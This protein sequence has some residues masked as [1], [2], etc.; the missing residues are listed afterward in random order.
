[1]E[2]GFYLFF[3]KII[4]IILCCFL[5]C[6]NSIAQIT[7]F[8]KRVQLGC[9][10]TILTSLEVTDSCY[11]ITGTARDSL[12]CQVNALFVKF[13]TLGNEILHKVLYDS[14][15]IY[16]TWGSSLQTDIDN[17]LIVSTYYVDSNSYR[18]GF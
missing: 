14:L 1:M 11:Y 8:N 18:G 15:G 10:N 7:T 3:M 4:Y 5:Y 12:T 13:D 16:G 17:N 6:N 2:I 9:G